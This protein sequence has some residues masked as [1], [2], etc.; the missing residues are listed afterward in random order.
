[1]ISRIS[2]QD[3]EQAQTIEIT[4][5]ASNCLDEFLWS[6]DP[7]YT[8]TGKTESLGEAIDEQHIVFIYV[9]DVGGG[10]DSGPV[11][12]GCVVV[13]SVEFIHDECCSVSADVLDLSK[14]G[15]GND[16]SS[17]ISWIG[18]LQLLE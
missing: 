3:E 2:S 15:I 11:A 10:A 7:R 16:L 6:Y 12:V 4:S 5:T 13:A 18:G 1:M 14:L 8:E 9:L 17:G